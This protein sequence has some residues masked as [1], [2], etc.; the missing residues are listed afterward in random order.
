MVSKL[1]DIN[2]DTDFFFFFWHW[3][4]RPGSKSKNNHVGQHQS[5]KK[6]NSVQQRKALSKLKI[7]QPTEWGK[8]ICPDGAD[9]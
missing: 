9:I 4:Q 3:H 6:K 7:K 2:L 8:K 1:F 5:G